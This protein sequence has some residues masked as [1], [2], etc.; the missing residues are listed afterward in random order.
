VGGTVQVLA[1]PEHS[2]QRVV[3][4][5]EEPDRP[6]PRGEADGGGLAAVR[7]DHDETGA[8]RETAES[9]PED[10]GDVHQ[11]ERGET[12]HRGDLQQGLEV[13]PVPGGDPRRQDQTEHFLV[14]EGDAQFPA[15]VGN[16]RVGEPDKEGVPQLPGVAEHHRTEQTVRELLEALVQ[17]GLEAVPE[18]HRALPELQDLQL[19]C[20]QDPEHLPEGRTDSGRGQK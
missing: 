12:V 9:A 20:R 1:E 10:G 15:A 4:P 2:E 7:E 13:R 19:R 5:V 14:P 18:D 3:G 6:V 8:L 16:F 11:G 17:S